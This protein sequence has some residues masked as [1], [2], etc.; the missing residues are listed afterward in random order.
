MISISLGIV[1][2]LL[3]WYAIL[4]R[5][6][7][8]MVL[9]LCYLPFAG[10]VTL[11]LYPDTLPILYKDFFFV[12]PAYLAYWG[13]SQDRSVQ[14]R[15][16]ELV[17]IFMWGLAVLVFLQS[18]NPGLAAPLVAAI[19]A[20]VWL[21]YLPLLFLAFAMIESR[22][23]LVRV[24][25]LM[26]VLAW[27]PCCIGIVEWLA[28][29]AFGYEEIMVAIYGEAAEGATQNFVR[30]DIGGEFYR[31]PSTFTFV[32]QYFGFTLSMLVP[33][34]ALAK[35]DDSVSWRRFAM[36]TL[37]LAML[38]SFM[39][40]AR[41][42]YFFV[43][44]L[45]LMAY[46][47]DGM[48]RGVLKVMLMVVPILFVAL[49]VAGI[50][51]FKLYQLMKELLLTYS[52]EIAREGLM[53]AIEN[54]PFGTGTGMNTG[55]ARYAF[56][57]PE[58]FIGIEN[59]YAKAVVELGIPGLVVVAG[60]FLILLRQGYRIQSQL[61]DEGL[62]GCASVMLAFIAT[63]ALNSFKGWQIDLDPVNV[64]FWVFAGMLLKLKYLDQH[65]RTELEAVPAFG[66]GHSAATIRRHG[67]VKGLLEG[68]GGK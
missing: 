47:L 49:Y 41:A 33:A 65:A 29:A 17:R 60:L 40:G 24:L 20:K 23:G 11:S 12:I 61:R 7:L 57:D 39:S 16:P 19:G 8:G 56:D 44:L 42:A 67:A 51:P 2:M 30:F 32:T 34:Y 14:E 31:I 48:F 43:P 54:S 13:A 4:P 68:G 25:R 36:L 50:D 55:P 59:Y 5:W 1:V 53:D 52:D 38:A 15:V 27:I 35:L 58:G 21:F 46:W 62:R 37:V 10:V 22:D 9:L 18:F 45:L 63:T 64:Y 6:Q 28:S 26:V 3:S 66:Y